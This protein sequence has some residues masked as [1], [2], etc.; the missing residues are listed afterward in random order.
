MIITCEN[1]LL[2]QSDIESGPKLHGPW[3]K[4]GMPCIFFGTSLSF[5]NFT[6]PKINLRLQLR[7]ILSLHP[8]N[9]FNLEFLPCATACWFS[10]TEDKLVLFKDAKALRLFPVQSLCKKM[11]KKKNTYRVGGWDFKFYENS[12][13]KFSYPKIG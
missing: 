2:A 8:W 13:Q 10:K 7:P 3:I 11:Q 4:I 5:K 6:G 1:P 9:T 12:D